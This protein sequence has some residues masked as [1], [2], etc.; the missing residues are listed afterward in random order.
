MGES[1]VFECGSCGYESRTVRWGVGVADPRRRFLPA[2]CLSCQDYVEVDLTGADL[3]VD[4]F[5]CDHCGSQVFFVE[6]AASY[7]C[8]KCGSANLQLRQGPAYW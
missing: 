8:P 3:V 5:A 6:R 7:N 2:L 4:E 1:T